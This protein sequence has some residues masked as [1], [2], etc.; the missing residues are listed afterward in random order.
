[1]LLIRHGAPEKEKTGIVLDGKYYDTSG[2]NGG[3]DYNE[4]F[5]GDR[6]SVG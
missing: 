6:K 5:F 3:E 2:F 4:K 1:M